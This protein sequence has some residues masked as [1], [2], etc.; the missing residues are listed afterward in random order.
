[1]REN[2]LLFLAELYDLALF[3]SAFPI[4]FLSCWKIYSSPKWVEHGGKE[5]YKIIKVSRRKLFSNIFNVSAIPT[6]STK[7]PRETWFQR[8]RIW[9]QGFQKLDIGFLDFP[10]GTEVALTSSG[11]PVGIPKEGISY[12]QRVF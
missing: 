4:S 6:L 7:Q 3:L 5:T 2:K 8:Y 9:A 1:M 10:L 12:D 11:F